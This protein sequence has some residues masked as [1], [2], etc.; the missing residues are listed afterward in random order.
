MTNLSC[1]KAYD[2][3]GS[4][5]NEI[6]PAFAF[7]LGQA[8]VDVSGFDKIIIGWDARLSGSLLAEHLAAG[9]KS[10]NGIPVFLGMC[11]T[12]EIY[13]VAL[14]Q[15]CS[16]AVMITGS[17]NPADENGFKIV[18]S[19]AYPVSSENGLNEIG[20]KVAEILKKSQGLKAISEK[21]IAKTEVRSQ[22]ITWLLDYIK[23]F[24]A[25][26]LKIVA[27]CGN[28]CAG[29]LVKKLAE[30][31]PHE[32][33]LINSEPDGN[34]PNGVPNPLLPEKRSATANAVKE[35]QADF[36]AAWDGD[37]D[38]CFFYDENGNFIE[39]YYL[40][41]L[42]SEAI[43]K[44]NSG[45]KIIHDPRLYWN[46]EEIVRNNGGVPIK[47][48]TG[49]AFM[50]ARMRK[51]NAI[52]GGEM[53]SHHYFRDF[54][55]CDSGILPF[56]LLTNLL[57]N[58]GKKLSEILQ[59][60]IVAYPCSGEINRPVANADESIKK[61]AAFYQDQAKSAEW[62][63]GLDMDLGDWRFS[64]RKS[65]TEPL[66]RLNVESRGDEKLMKE[67]TAEILNRLDA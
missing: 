47:S 59:K 57:A 20:L 4:V 63:D 56:L 51:E 46:T 61:I 21:E 6:T 24:N 41:G 34:F 49:H 65:N 26:P 23:P 53:S 55:Y 40:V 43:L 7:A 5:N 66:L 54:G 8:L 62:M 42:L 9:I 58:T 64:L 48:K 1:F 18:K 44:N 60:R 2:I 16:A 17:H 22:F 36:G 13:Y 3:R 30:C 52:Y 15:P 25:K 32:I 67:K 14:H 50:K 10:K 37:A 35:Y 11:C 33:I 19:G 38:R 39:G 31:L 12:E 29:L 45:E 27:D 28:G